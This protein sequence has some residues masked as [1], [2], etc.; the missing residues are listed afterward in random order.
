[1]TTKEVS[2]AAVAAMIMRTSRNWVSTKMKA[3]VIAFMSLVLMVGIASAQDFRFSQVQIEGNQ[4]VEPATI[5]SY[6]NIARGE[7]VNAGDLNDAFQ[8]IL[9]SGLFEDV[10]LIPSGNTLVIRVQEFPTINRISIEGNRRIG[11]EDLLPLLRSQPRRV[12]SPTLAEQDA[13]T[14][15]EAYTSQ[16]RLAATV[17]PSIIRRSENRVDLVFEVVEGRTVEVE[18][19]SFIGN[20]NFSDRRLRGVLETKQA[21][22]FR[23]LIRSDT[24]LA[25]RIEFDKQVLQDFYQSRGYVD[26]ETVSVNSEL[27]RERDGFLVTFNVREGQQFKFGE[28]TAV[29]DLED[30][31][32]DDFQEAIRVRPGVVYNP[33]LVENTIARMERLALQQGLNFIRVEPRIARNDRDLTLDVEFA[34]TR[35][36]RVFVERID[37]EGNTTTLDRVVRRQFRIIEGD[38]FN[39]REIRRSAERIRALGYF[40][41][42]DVNAR[43]GSGPDRVIIDVDVEE[44][45]T[46]SLSFGGSFSNSDGIGAAISFTERNFLGRGQLLAFGVNTTASTRG[47]NFNF[48]EPAFLGRDLRAGLLLEYRTT[49]RDNSDFNSRVARF[50]PSLT[51]P[52]A[53]NSFLTVR[54]GYKSSE[55]LDVD[56]DSS[57]LLKDEEDEGKRDAGFIGYSFSYDS[58]RTGLDPNT[59]F[60]L[61]F[62]QDFNGLGGNN[63]YIET[64]ALV[65]AET[66]VLNEDVVLRATLEGGA[67]N[68][69]SGDSL[70]LDR[71]RIGPRRLRG[72]ESNGIGPRDLDAGNEDVLGGNY[73]AVARFEAEF[74]LGLPE[75]YGITGGVFYDIGSLWGLDNTDNGRVDDSFRLRSA[76]GVSIFWAT[77]FGPLRFNF[78]ETLQQEDYDDDQFFDLTVSTN[79]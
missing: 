17:I 48:V 70:I 37:I 41:T 33:A 50:Q 27:T 66:A 9:A 1:M 10:E 54:A 30:V 4:R 78:A 53:E 6:A 77:G 5:L 15:T 28:V 25:D 12:Y 34:I 32:P 26:F 21:G 73:F 24:F 19:L 43:E 59:G 68:V 13:I 45:P 49:E 60:V 18:R 3:A 31:N 29:S 61:R 74:P 65:G 36:P 35:G 57:D 51:F 46:G 75:E 55:I 67:L 56:D 38:P 63:S 2:S 40:S 52:V 22:L 76:V 58:R 69:L 72:F 39:P 8:N 20:R 42:A 62:G 44:Q 23:A 11:D 64:T 7:P 71:F 14:M 79:F 47:Y 16:G